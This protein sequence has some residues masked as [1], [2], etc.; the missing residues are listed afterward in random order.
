MK[1]STASRQEESFSECGYLLAL[2]HV[3]GRLRLR[4]L[5]LAAVALAAALSAAGAMAQSVTGD[6]Y[7][8]VTDANGAVIPGARVTVRNV[9]T[10][11]TRQTT[12]DGGGEFR[13][14]SLPAADYQVEAEAT[15]FV[16]GV[17]SFKL[18]VGQGLAV[19][20]TLKTPGLVESVMVSDDAGVSVQTDSAALGGVIG[21]RQITE[22]PLN[23][24]NIDQ[25]ALLEPGVFST[26][27]R[28]IGGTIHGT[29]ININGAMGRSS[30]YLLDGTNVSDTFNNG[31]GSTAD[32]FLGVDAVREFRVLTNS[33]GPEYGQAS[34]GVVTI[35]T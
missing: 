23:G 24:R 1:L 25:L 33:Y 29:Q 30:R 31:L 11:A 20:L 18:A 16:K 10:D 15:G 14:A 6:V 13:L 22:L 4:V 28:S 34:G 26:T 32:T 27:N 8:K 17:E 5:W 7:G 35:V 9:G 19:N 21:S 2:A 12:T 3:H